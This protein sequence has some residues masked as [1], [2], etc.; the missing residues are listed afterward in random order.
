MKDLVSAHPALK[1]LDLR[2]TNITDTG[3]KHV[4]NLKSLQMIGLLGTKV[5]SAGVK[6]LQAALPKCKVYGFFG[7]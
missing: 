2:G 4:Q 5:T 1:N 3:L 7:K 6:D